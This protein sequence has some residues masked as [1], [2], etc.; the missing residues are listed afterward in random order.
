MS[1]ISST[2]LENRDSVCRKIQQTEF[3]CLFVV[4]LVVLAWFVVNIRPLEL[5]KQSKQSSFAVWDSF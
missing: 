4:V 2:K 5:P 1:C 3:R